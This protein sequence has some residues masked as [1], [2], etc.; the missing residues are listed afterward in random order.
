MASCVDCNQVFSRR[1]AM[2]RHYRDS[3]TQL[4]CHQCGRIFFGETALKK[5]EKVHDEP[6]LHRCTSCN[7]HFNRKNNLTHHMKIC[8]VK[9]PSTTTGFK[10]KI[11]AERN[12][13]AKRLKTDRIIR[14]RSA[15][16]GAAATWRLSVNDDLKNSVFE[17]E[18][19]IA[20][21]QWDRKALKFTMA[22]HVVFVKAN[23][24]SVYTDPPVTLN[25]QPFSVYAETNISFCLVK[26][27]NQLETILNNSKETDLDGCWMM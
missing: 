10:R 9:P 17:M 16:N 13:R 8:Y 11:G 21:Y 15:F 22:I 19:K 24:S 26:A 1:D 5:H 27:Y 12:V 4:N 6:K 2:L 25:T 20:D 3:H 23:D 14:I 18:K 7:K